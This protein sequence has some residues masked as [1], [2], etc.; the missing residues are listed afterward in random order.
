MELSFDEQEGWLVASMD[1]PGWCAKLSAAE[2]GVFT[3]ALLGFYQKANVD[4]VREQ[5]EALSNQAKELGDVASKAAQSG[6]EGKPGR[7]SRT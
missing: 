3:A 6:T 4:L 7:K 1:R 2:R 5:M